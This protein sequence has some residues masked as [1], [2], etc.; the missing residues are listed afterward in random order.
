MATTLAFYNIKGGVGKTSSAVNIAY[1]AAQEG[2]TLLWDLDPQGAASFYL[3]TKPHIKGGIKGLVA[4]KQETVAV[5]KASEY[6]NLDVLPSDHSY[7]Q[8]DSLINDSKSPRKF[9][10]RFIKPLQNH[11]Q[12]I[13]IDCAPTFTKASDSI[14]LAA[15][16]VLIPTI[17][18]VLSLRTLEQLTQHMSEKLSDKVAHKAFFTML[19]RRKR[20]HED[21]VNQYVGKRAK[22]PFLKSLIPYASI[23][24][25]MGLQQQPLNTYA[26]NSPA[27][28]AYQQLWREIRK[29]AKQATR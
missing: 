22:A 8:L 19:D 24:E 17:P 29:A 25:K 28:E 2:K 6:P 20:M 21:I 27:G 26:N 14:L 9:I 12:T 16:L 18:T 11:Y 1:L 5:I 4:G 7:R 23:V 13:I 10:D 15:D 3:K